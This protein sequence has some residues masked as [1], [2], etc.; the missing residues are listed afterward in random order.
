MSKRKRFGVSS[1]L[2]QGLSETVNIVENNPSLFRNAVIPVQRIE[3]D[4]DNPRQLAI[5]QQEV[6]HGLSSSA[7]NKKQKSIEL[8]ALRL[9]SHTIQSSGMINPIL[10]YKFEDKYQVIAGERR[11]LATLLAKKTEIEARIYHSKPSGFNLK[12]VQWVENTAREDLNLFERLNNIRDII[13][14]YQEEN[15]QEKKFT[16]SLLKELTGLSLPQSTYYINVL[17]APEIIHTFIKEGKLNS[18][19]KVALL[20]SIKSDVIQEKAIQACLQG[21]S[22]KQLRQCIANLEQLDKQ[23]KRNT[24]KQKAGQ[25]SLGKARHGRIVQE[26]VQALIQTKKYKIPSAL[27]SAVDWQDPVSS[28]QAFFKIISILEQ[29][30]EETV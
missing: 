26:I 20:V 30:I 4:P 25:V 9:L 1:A 5:S 21:M 2:G 11:F 19:D 8:E 23:S 28:S 24:R 10:V 12:L 29:S 27:F 22:L 7:S 13:D 18:L 15:K 14:A 6:I 16:A 3:L 17:A